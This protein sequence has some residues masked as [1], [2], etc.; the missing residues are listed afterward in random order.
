MK[1][2]MIAMA[3]IEFTKSKFHRVMSWLWLFLSGGV[4]SA[5]QVKCS[6]SNE[7]KDTAVADIVDAKDTAATDTG[8]DMFISPDSTDVFKDVPPI[9]YGPPP[10]DVIDSKTDTFK[11]VPPIEYGPPPTD[12]VE[13]KTDTFD[14]IPPVDYGPPPSDTVD[15][16]TDE[17][18]DIPVVVY[19]P[20]VSD[21]VEK[22]DQGGIQPVYGMPE[23]GPPNPQ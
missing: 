22:E 5:S 15:I 12:I 1:V 11:D 14:D 18:K 13:T 20:Y 4:V 2:F 6:G 17:F 16:K 21:V 23:Y 9:E 3:L 10:T 19:G 8:K 7:A